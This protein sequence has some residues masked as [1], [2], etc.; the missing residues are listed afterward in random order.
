MLL[1][2]RGLCGRP[3]GVG[4]NLRLGVRDRSAAHANPRSS[5]PISI[6]LHS[7]HPSPPLGRNV[8][9]GWS[10][11]CSKVTTPFSRTRTS[12]SATLAGGGAMSVKVSPPP[13]AANTHEPT[14]QTSIVRPAESLRTDPQQ[15]PTPDV[16][17]PL[18]AGRS[19][20]SEGDQK[21]RS[22]RSSSHLPRLTG[23]M[24][25]C[26]AL[27]RTCHELLIAVEK[28]QS[29]ASVPAACLWLFARGSEGR[30]VELVNY[31][32]DRRGGHRARL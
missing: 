31:G 6:A 14:V 2:G 22:R 28:R 15:V 8:R 30:P 29:G 25:Q 10:R 18:A 12:T 7:S 23:R 32:L 27:V 4:A 11:R 26:S 3:P 9:T 20:K 17:A 24:L 13:G 21:S 16:I 19:S 5:T 1:P